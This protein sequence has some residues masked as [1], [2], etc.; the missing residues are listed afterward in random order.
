MTVI[1]LRRFRRLPDVPAFGACAPPGRRRL[2]AVPLVLVLLLG[3]ALGVRASGV[4]DPVDPYLPPLPAAARVA[5]G[6]VR[7]GQ[8]ADIDFLRLRDAYGVRAI[9]DV[10]G[11]DV[12]EQAV[13]GSLG[14]RTLQLNVA[15]GRPPTAQDL[16]SLVRFLRSTVATRPGSG[17]TGVVYLHDF[18]G[19]GPVVIVS[20]MLQV[21]R[22]AALATVLEGLRAGGAPAL[23]GVE[24]LALSEVAGVRAGTIP[25]GAYAALRGESW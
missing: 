19:R 10:D 1:P 4:L 20:A 7:G 17:G 14:F 2:V 18:D 9:V 23:T 24:S 5:P 11:M 13:T 16:L 22:G 8:P 6:L 15:E 3:A 21:L 25:G 12:E